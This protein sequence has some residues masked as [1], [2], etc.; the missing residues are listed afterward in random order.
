MVTL[1]TIQ[2]TVIDHIG[3]I[4]RPRLYLTSLNENNMTF[5]IN[6]PDTNSLRDAAKKRIPK[7]AFD[8]LNG[9][10]FNEQAL[11]R[12]R[13]QLQHSIFETKLTKSVS[14]PTFNTPLFGINYAFP[15][16]IA[17]MGM[18]GLIWPNSPQILAKAAYKHKLPFVLSTVSSASIEEIGEISE[19]IAWFQLYNPTEESI[20]RSMITRAK[21]AGYQVLVVTI[22]VPTYGYRP[23]DIKNGLSM[24]PQM[25]LKNILQM[26]KRPQ[27]SAATIRYGIPQMV[28]LMQYANKKIPAA[29]L[30][31]FLNTTVMGSVDHNGLKEIRDLWQGALIIKGISSEY[32]I[33]TAIAIGADGIII[34][35]HGGRQLDRGLSSI[36]SLQKYGKKYQDKLTILCDSG[37]ESGDDI[38]VCLANGAKAAF[39][40]RTFMHGTAA[41]GNNGADHVIEMLKMQLTQ[42]AN[43]LK[44]E[45]MSDFT[46][47]LIS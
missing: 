35:N 26:M 19:G 41:L 44:C 47:I 32:D 10:C 11:A 18:Q 30:E 13:A 43:Q 39:L 23:K 25:T 37:I 15:F 16:G 17:P 9:G 7:F 46:D 5:N 6:Y 24:P 28:T 4:N 33:N 20:R 22:D 36:E 38:A 14:E 1:K 34:S 2:A 8:Y 45:K 42:V 29:E 12:N 21:N 27:W 3:H 31:V 40:G